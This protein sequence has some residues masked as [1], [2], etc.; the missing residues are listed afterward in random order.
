[1]S[2]LR[3]PSPVHL[4]RT[5]GTARYGRSMSFRAVATLLALGLWPGAAHATSHR[6]EAGAGLDAAFSDV[7]PLPDVQPGQPVHP[8]SAVTGPP[9]HLIFH[10]RYQGVGLGRPNVALTAGFNTDT[11]FADV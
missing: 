8:L 7:G 5:G 11:L 6:V 9:S 1:M 4:W 2:M 3:R 10:L